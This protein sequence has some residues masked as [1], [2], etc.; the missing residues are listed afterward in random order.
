MTLGL[1]AACVGNNSA[2][3]TPPLTL[4]CPVSQSVS[5]PNGAAVVVNYPAP[6]ATGGKAPITVSCA[7]AS[8]TAFT[9][10]STPVTCTARDTGQATASCGFVVAVTLTP[11]LTATRFI[12]FGD[13]IT[14]GSL[15]P[16]CGLST[17]N[18]CSITTLMSA[19]QRRALMQQL[20]A[21]LE[22]SVAA[23]PRVLQSLLTE[24]YPSQ[25]TITVTNEG[26]PGESVSD[27][28]TRLPGTLVPGSMV[29]LLMEGANDINQGRPVD[30][31]AEDLR[32]MIRT[33]Q[34]RGMTVFL[35]T[36]LPQRQRGC[37]AYDFCDGVED[38]A[39]L[40]TRLRVIAQSE[41]ATLVDLYPAFAGQTDTLLGPDGLHP[42]AAGYRKMA[43]VF[44]SAVTQQLEAR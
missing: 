9:V 7:P 2:P 21:N 16:D 3:S 33:G 44:F 18:S 29:L 24:R 26:L 25:S 22:V 30:A 34:A 19:P 5:S 6:V 35:G 10:A 28:K 37:R 8:G 17:G 39:L 27:G 42:N 20:F 4:A 12:A 13:S 38:T 32:S 31:I 40:N 41:R 11:R 1:I 43:D 15:P 23:Y 14:A 36:L